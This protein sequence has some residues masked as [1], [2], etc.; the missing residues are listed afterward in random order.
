MKWHKNELIVQKRIVFDENPIFETN[1]FASNSLINALED[2]NI[3]GEVSYIADQDLITLLMKV[4]GVMICPCAITLEDVA[5]PFTIDVDEIYS[6]NNA[7]EL[8]A[9]EID[10]DELDIEP[11]LF[12]TI[13]QEVP[14]KV[15]KQD[16]VS[17]PK[18]DGWSV[19]S[20]EEFARMKKEELDPR[21]AI[22]KD[23]KFSDKEE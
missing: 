8:N 9:L 19:K 2:V 15:V 17:Y 14:I 4:D 22:L 11:L 1:L 13:M 20:E 23:F 10:G 5:Y 16:I 6:F 3:S 7:Q 12:E 21:L 18:G